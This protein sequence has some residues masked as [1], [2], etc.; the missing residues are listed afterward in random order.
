M[1]ENFVYPVAAR[2]LQKWKDKNLEVVSR[3]NGSAHFRFLFHGSTCN[4]GGTPFKA[5]LHTEL[6]VSPPNQSNPKI[7]A[8]WIE[9]PEDEL[10][11]AKDMCGYRDRGDGFW[12]DLTAFP[13]MQGKSITE[14]LSENVAMNHAGCFCTVP[15]VNQKWRIAL[16][17]IH[18]AINSD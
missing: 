3:A 2:A 9:I 17:T 7:N 15:M 6:D 4:D 18:F 13:E 10:E 5:F 11:A 16:S 1:S 12:D 14:I 8:A